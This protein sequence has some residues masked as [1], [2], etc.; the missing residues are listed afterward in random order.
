MMEFAVLGF[1][2]YRPLSMYDLKKAME[3]STQHF[4]SASF[5]TLH[6][7]LQRLS[8]QGFVTGEDQMGNGRNKK[9]YTITPAGRSHFV[10]WL[11]QDV[12]AERVS[13]PRLLRLFFLGHMAAA[14]REELLARFLTQME[15]GAEELERLKAQVQQVTVPPGWEDHMAYQLATLEFGIAHH[16]FVK[17]WYQAKLQA[18]AGSG[19]AGEV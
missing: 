16:R 15:A 1:L 7:L 11:G 9:V 12:M 8:K 3:R 17:E 5:G 13:D 2:L 10:E 4:L 19:D 14:E 6:P 18:I